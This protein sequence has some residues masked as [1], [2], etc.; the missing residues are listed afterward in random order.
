MKPG[1]GPTWRATI[2]RVESEVE[3]ES[4][5]VELS[6]RRHEADT[7]IPARAMSEADRLVAEGEAARIMEDGKATAEAVRLMREEWDGGQAQELF[8]IRMFPDLVDKVTRVVAE[9]LRVDKLTIL[10]GGGEGL[11]NYVRN[12]TSSAVVMM[13]Q[14]KNATGVDFARIAERAGKEGRSDDVPKELG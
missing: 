11:P 13:E 6:Q 1:N 3:L 4:K 2:A 5:R 10:D 7:V 8:M 9:N 14:M 12:L